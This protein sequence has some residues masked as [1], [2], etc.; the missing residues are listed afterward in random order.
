MS[1][2]LMLSLL[3]GQVLISSPASVGAEGVKYM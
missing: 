1:L 2:R 3:R